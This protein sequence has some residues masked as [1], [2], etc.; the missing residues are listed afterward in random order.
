MCQDFF[1]GLISLMLWC[2]LL[3]VLDKVRSA[4]S[5]LNHCDDVDF[6]VTSCG[7]KL[8]VKQAGDSPTFSHISDKCSHGHGEHD[9]KSGQIF[10][11]VALP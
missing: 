4:Q 1:Q 3:Q 10:R 2:L 8:G 11:L 9:I 5:L 6:L 7:K